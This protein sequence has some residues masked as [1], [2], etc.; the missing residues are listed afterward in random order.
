MDVTDN[1]PVPMIVVARLQ[2][3]VELINKALRKAGHAVHCHWVTE[4]NDL[5]DTLAQV[6]AHMVIG[7]ITEDPNEM[8]QTLK[9]FRQFAAAIPALI[10]RDQ[11]T[12]AVIAQAMQLGARDVVSLTHVQRLQWVVTREL[13]AFRQERK[14]AATISTAQEYREQLKSFMS[15]SADAI[16]HMQDG[17]LVDA[18]PAWLELLGYKNED[19]LT[20]QPLM[21]CFDPDSHSALKGALAACLQG[22]WSDHE[23]K[24]NALLADG[25][26]LPLSLQ[27]QAVDLE[28]ERAVQ[29]R[30]PAQ[31]KDSRALNE[32]LSDALQ[33]DAS[34]SFLQRR[35]FIER[36]RTALT[37]PIKAGIRQLLCI[38]PDKFDKLADEIGM[39]NV[40]DFV[41]Q[42]ASI[43]KEHLQPTDMAGRFGDC[44]IYVLMERGNRAD[45]DA[46]CNHIISKI[47]KHVFTVAD[48]SVTCSC[49][50]GA[51]VINPQGTHLNSLLKDITKGLNQA[52]QQ[53]GNRAQV[54]DHADDDTRRAETDKIWVRLIKS[55]LMDNRFRLLQQPIAS[56]SGEDTGMCDVLVRMLNEQDNE[57]LPAEFLAVAERND[58]MK[59]IDRWVIGSALSFCSTRNIKQLFVRLSKDS[60]LD[61]SLP[62]WLETQ[63]GAHRVNPNRVV[64]EISEQVATE[65]L[66][67]TVELS[68]L[69]HATGFRFALEHAG[70]S[71]DPKALIQ[72]LQLDYLKFDG[73]L[74]QGLALNI[75]LQERLQ[76]LVKA[77]RD[78]NIRTIAER[79]EDANTLAVLWQLGLELIQG[80]FVHEPEQVTL[81]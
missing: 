47:G 69:L 52:Q 62:K 27:L 41:A 45:I 56:L 65:Y 79:V 11:V 23:L 30:V 61:K 42:F 37:A 33:R 35:F 12:E 34:T 72:H 73:A 39:E 13:N 32:R 8:V 57:I 10:V 14:L 50:I 17:I 22:K 76:A 54:V 18:N 59:N 53:G 16:A 64:F 20:G 1:S 28:G 29:I 80:Y 70:N 75:P 3:Q 4:L 78:R 74:M 49:T 66:R 43:L 36:L 31:R 58:L 5:G 38:Q 44:A 81:G 24:V 51:G 48:K 6:N 25:T 77:A 19:D 67:N 9:V 40:E 55:A 71:R 46:W 15:G 26:T 21:D 60:V 2:D 68:R 63:L 7:V